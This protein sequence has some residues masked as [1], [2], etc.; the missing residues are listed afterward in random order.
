MEEKWKVILYRSPN[1]DFP[2]QKFIDSLELKAQSKVRDSVK[3]LQ[4]FGVMIGS[5]HAK[6]LTGTDL[7]ELRIL[8]SDSLRIIYVAVVQK[9]FLLLHEFKKKSQKT[10]PKE[11]KIAIS[12]LNDYK[13]RI[14]S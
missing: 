11:I 9:T 7:W 3:L 5:P 13:L 8:G 4:E 2:V 10:P 1:G 6:K 14:T 12:R